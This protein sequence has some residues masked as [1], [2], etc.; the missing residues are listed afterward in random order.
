MVLLAFTHGEHVLS[1]FLDLKKAYDTVWKDGIMRD[2]YNLGL[3]GRLPL[4]IQQFLLNRS[5]KVQVNNNNRTHFH[6]KE[7][8]KV[9]FRVLLYLPLK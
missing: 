8:L 3:R 4:Y 7:S 6:K 5:C 9:V 2:F 1:V